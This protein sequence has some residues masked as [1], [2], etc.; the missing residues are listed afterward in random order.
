LCESTGRRRVTD[1]LAWS[2]KFE[3]LSISR[4]TLRSLG[5]TKEQITSLTDEEIQ[6]IADGVQNIYFDGFQICVQSLT[7]LTL[8]E[9]SSRHHPVC[10]VLVE[11]SQ[12]GNLRGYYRHRM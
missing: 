9:R 12:E 5:F 6:A 3:V 1:S 4:L 8:A 7:A 11:L 10:C 2:K